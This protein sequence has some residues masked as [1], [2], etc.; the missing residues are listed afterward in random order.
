MFQCAP[1][2]RSPSFSSGIVV[3]TS[4]LLLSL[5][6]PYIPMTLLNNFI[7]TSL[8]STVWACHQR[9]SSFSKF[10]QLQCWSLLRYQLILGSMWNY[11]NLVKTHH[12]RREHTYDG[13][14]FHSQDCLF[15]TKRILG[16]F[17]V[18]L[19]RAPGKTSNRC[20]PIMQ[21]ALASRIWSTLQWF[22]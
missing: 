12:Q 5:K 13:L 22:D 14:Q 2:A 17:D 9:K 4:L 21:S 19:V 8:F 20:K 15:P 7:A 10:V 3:R 1:S 18:F 11:S 16:S 6:P